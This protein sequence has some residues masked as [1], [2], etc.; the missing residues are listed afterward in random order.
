MSNIITVFQYRWKILVLSL[1]I[2]LLLTS[3]I[4]L[5]VSTPEVLGFLSFSNIDV[6]ASMQK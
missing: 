2:Q 6:L 4:H 1:V 3:L 5:G